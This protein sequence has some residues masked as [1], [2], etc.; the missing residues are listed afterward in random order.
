MRKKSGKERTL[1]N[2]YVVFWLLALP[3]VVST[4]E[5]FIGTAFHIKPIFIPGM[6]WFVDMIVSENRSNESFAAIGYTFFVIYPLYAL[7]FTGITAYMCFFKKRLLKRYFYFS[8]LISLLP[9]YI[10]LV[11]SR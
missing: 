7:L 11:L 9:L 3:L 6:L 1:Y 8:L 10:F 4:F 5:L 2:W